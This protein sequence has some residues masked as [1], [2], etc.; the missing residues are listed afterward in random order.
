MRVEVVPYDRRWPEQFA[1]VA[2]GLVELLAGVEMVGIEHVGSTAVPG[3]PAKPV[4]DVDV[5]VGR[6]HLTAAVDALVAGGYT[7]RG[8]L[9]V[10]DRHAFLAPDEDPRR[11]VYVV[12]DGSLALRNHRVVRDVLRAD[13]TMRNRYAETKQAL[14]CRDLRDIDEYVAGKSAVLS[15]VLAAGGL[16]AD[17]LGRV[18]AHN[19]A[20]PV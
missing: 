7:H 1:V 15:E 18:A 2:A 6:E 20:E 4:L 10:T 17:D 13:A 11:H 16:D 12:L 14:A 9:G 8:D 3:L 5:V 19:P